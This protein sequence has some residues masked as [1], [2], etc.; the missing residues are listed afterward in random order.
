VGVPSR[1]VA[2]SLLWLI[3]LLGCRDSLAPSGTAEPPLQARQWFSE[4][5][6]CSGLAGDFDQIVWFVADQPVQRDNGITVGEWDSPNRIVLARAWYESEDA[7]KHE[8]LHFL[9]QHTGHPDPPFGTC[10]FLPRTN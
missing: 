8:M 5:E 10:A 9:L 6:A 3:G 4:L 1:T 2:L 7:V